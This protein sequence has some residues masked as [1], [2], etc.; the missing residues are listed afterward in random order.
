APEVSFEDDPLR[1]LRAAR[2]TATL[3]FEPDVALVRAIE[4]M[5]ERL[6]IVSAERVRD[7]LSK[8]LV[9]DD[10][11][12]GLWLSART[13]LSDEFVPELNAMR[14]EQDPIHRHK[15]VLAHTI[16]VVAKTSPRLRIRLAALLHDVG[17]PRTRGYGPQGV[18]FHHHE[19]VGARMAR[20]RMLELRYPNELVNDVTRLVEL[21]LRFHTYR[22]GWT[23]SAVR[24]YVRDAGPLL[25]DLNELTRCDC[26][27]RD[28]RKAEALGRR[29]DE[30]VARIAELR[31]REELAKIRPALDGNQVMRFLGVRPG[32]VVGEA[33]DFLLELRLE[34]GAMSEDEASA[35]LAAWARQRGLEPSEAGRAERPG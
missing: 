10:P 29:M 19:V 33:L 18:T 9:A 26:T 24:R 15:D 11:S 35:R 32:P 28:A 30:L 22:M 34:E 12:S 23:D 2:F 16:A 25:D 6:K 13:G 7:E 1:M 8:L 14:L 27:T 17:K 3:A 21:H 4:Q 20:E 5:H 31:E